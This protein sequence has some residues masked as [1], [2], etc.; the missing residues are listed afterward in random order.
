MNNFDDISEINL[1]LDDDKEHRRPPYF[2]LCGLHWTWVY[3][4]NEAI[5]LLMTGKVVYAS[6]DH[7]L[8]DE[9]YFAYHQGVAG[10]AESYK[11][12]K[13]KTGMSVLQYM[14]DNNVFPVYGVRI[15]TMNPVAKQKMLEIV[16]RYY[17]R[18]FQEQYEGTHLV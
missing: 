9:H 6:L 8:A 14:E 5:E 18:T 2:G 16:E 3:T 17:G 15:H 1:W 13:E 10:D 4:A 12:C 11:N 7:D